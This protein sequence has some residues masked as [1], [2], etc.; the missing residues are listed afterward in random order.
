MD[1]VDFGTW[2]DQ[3]D[4]VFGR[5]RLDRLSFVSRLQSE[6]S[7]Y[8]GYD[9][10]E[11]CCHVVQAI[12]LT[13]ALFSNAPGIWFVCW[14]WG[15][16]AC[17]SWGMKQTWEFQVPEHMKQAWDKIDGAESQCSATT[18]RWKQ[19]IWCWKFRLKSQP[20]FGVLS[21]WCLMR[22]LKWKIQKDPPGLW[23]DFGEFFSHS[24]HVQK[25]LAQKPGA[26][27]M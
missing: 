11:T 19:V 13:C 2:A 27:V 10:Y 6:Y 18:Q 21:S 7:E 14:R 16:E 1:P 17:Q 8:T 3:L 20:S 12:L 26:P 9:T 15:S 24:W 25:H 4:S 5:A 23:H 22:P